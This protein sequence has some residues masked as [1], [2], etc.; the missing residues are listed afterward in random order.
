MHTATAPPEDISALGHALRSNAN[1]YHPFAHQ[2]QIGPPDR[3]FIEMLDAYRESG[4]L[5]RLP[6]LASL[7]HG[8]GLSGTRR[9]AHWIQNRKVICF[10]WGSTL[11]LPMVQFNRSTMTLLPG[12]EDILAELVTV[13]N[14]SD[15][16]QWFSVPNTWL[17]GRSPADALASAAP[18]VL[19]A[20][21][22]ERHNSAQ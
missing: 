20:A 15:L 19:L 17:A 8:H 5:M 21:R 12:F 18:E 3:Q 16:A 14:D 22:A 11:W 10:D 4:G 9:L 13:F 6:E 7:W 1:A 2:P